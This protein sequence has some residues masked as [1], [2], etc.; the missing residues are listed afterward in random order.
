M[1]MMT[2]SEYFKSQRQFFEKMAEKYFPHTFK[3]AETVLKAM[4]YSFFA[5]GKRFR[6]VLALSVC[7]VIGKDK[8]KVIPACLSIEMVHTYSLI[9][10]D[11]PSMDNDD[12]RRGKPSN[13]RVFGEGMAILAGDGLL[14]EAF[15]VASSYPKGDEFVKGRLEFVKA[16][17]DAAG[18]RG[19]VGGQVMDIEDKKRFDESYLKKLHASKTGAMIKLSALTPLIFFQD[20][21]LYTEI[22]N[23]ASNLGMLF[24]ITDD[25]LDVESSTEKLGK[26]AGKDLKQHKLTYV[27][28]FGLEGAK[29]RAKEAFERAVS[30]VEKIPNSNYLVELARY[31][32]T[33]DR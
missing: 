20:Y 32:Y 18:I 2:F 3:E 30:Y 17:S 4:K 27:S 11:L 12:F 14:T 31:I 22:E 21:S 23:Y 9:H 16:L 6:P 28:L 15:Y 8:D 5:G 19:M 24:Q 26:T 13:H 7:D 1:E 25:I 10:D 33:R 29:K